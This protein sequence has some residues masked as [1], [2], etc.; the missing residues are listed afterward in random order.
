[1]TVNVPH[2]RR[3]NW[4]SLGSEPGCGPSLMEDEYAVP[5]AG[6]G[7]RG[8]ERLA[9]AGGRLTHLSTSGVGE[10]LASAG[11]PPLDGGQHGRPDGGRVGVGPQTEGGGRAPR[12]EQAVELRALAVA[13][14][15]GPR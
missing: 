1:M 5:A 6:S 3:S 13:H 7:H 4:G 2:G 12:E 8:V 14:L 9:G 15:R 11:A 10:R